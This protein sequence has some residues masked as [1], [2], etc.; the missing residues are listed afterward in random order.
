MAKI[1]RMSDR[2]HLKIDEITFVLAPL[3]YYQKQEIA[4][5]TKMDGGNEVFDLL[6]AQFTYIKYGLKD[7][8]GI[9]DYDGNKYELEFNGD[10][11]TENCVSEIMN[12]DQREKLTV[13]AW[14]LLNGVKELT[15]PVSG[16]PLEGVELEVKSQG[17]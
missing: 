17:K 12:L 6:K 2:I 5:C 10:E 16:E 7:I 11:L 9:E 3:N 13:S 14:Q 15:D 1:L 4:G 8:I